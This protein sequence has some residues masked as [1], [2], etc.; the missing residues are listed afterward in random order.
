MAISQEFSIKDLESFTGIKA[1]TIRIWEQRYG[2]LTPLRS[3][4]NIRKYSDKD[5]KWLLNVSFLNQLGYKISRIASM[6]EQEIHEIIWKHAKTDHPAEMALHT[7]KLAMIHFDEQLFQEVI[8]QYT[9]E[10]GMESTIRNVFLPFLNEIGNLWLADSICPAQEHFV[11]GLIRQK[12][13]AA[14][15]G[16]PPARVDNA[17]PLVLYLPEH[18]I[19]EISMIMLHFLLRHAGRKSIY[20]GSG[21]PFEDLERVKQQLGA[22][23][24]VSIYTTRSSTFFLPQYMSKISGQFQHSSCKFHMTGAGVSSIQSPDPSLITLYN[25]VGELKEN[26][27]RQ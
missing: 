2:I 10:H 3:D 17:M 8:G 22:V 15:D 21:V 27:D 6:K 5:L 9:S 18:E 19:H 11:S 14:I 25:S 16:L 26:L 23:H 7:L 12:L 13:F 20:L 1:H 4:G 24:F